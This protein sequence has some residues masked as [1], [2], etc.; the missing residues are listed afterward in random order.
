MPSRDFSHA[1]MS[2]AA[3]ARERAND[4]LR[5]ARHRAE[6]ALNQVM[7]YARQEGDMLAE[8]VGTQL[9]RAGQAVRADPVPAIVG[10]LG[11]A[12]LASLL[13]S[14]RRR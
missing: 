4:M 13:L 7:D 2:N 1:V 12:L 8:A 3:E 6:P 14:R 9:R 5:E 11:V 10:A